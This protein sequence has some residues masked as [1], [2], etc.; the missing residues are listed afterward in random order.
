M[1]DPGFPVGSANPLGGR[2][3][4]YTFAEFSKKKLYEIEKILSRRGR[5]P[6]APLNPLMVWLWLHLIA[7]YSYYPS[8]YR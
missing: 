5:T 8:I 6:G 1:P 2:V 7:N 4:T 3:P